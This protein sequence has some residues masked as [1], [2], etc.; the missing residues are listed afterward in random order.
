MKAGQAY[1]AAYHW[2]SGQWVKS[3]L[4]LTTIAGYDGFFNDNSKGTRGWAITFEVPFSSLGLSSKPADGSIWGISMTMHDRDNQSGGMVGDKSWPEGFQSNSP[5][6]WAQ[7]HFGL[8]YYGAIA[9]NVTGTDLI[10]NNSTR[11]IDV[12]DAGLGGTTPDLCGNNTDIWNSWGNNSDFHNEPDF[13]IQNQSKI[14]DWPCYT[15]YYVTFPLNTVPAN[16]TILSARLILHHVGS[17]G[18]PG[19]ATPSL[20]QVL[21]IAGDWAENSITWNNAPPPVENVSQTWL[22]VP[23]DYGNWPKIPRYW[24]VTAAAAKA[25]L[26]GQP[27]RLALYEA[28]SDYHS[29][30]YFSSSESSEFDPSKDWNIAGR[31]SLEIKWGN[32]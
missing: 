9:G 26:T 12:P 20:I 21:S 28:D 17:S 18:G 25:Y 29:G 6:T 22:D 13:N 19:Q 7:L 3:N 30:K 11:G 14:T 31:P 4:P 27:L 5:S 1:Q 2:Q 10:R 8:P 15:K 23:S 16:K 24:D 32:R